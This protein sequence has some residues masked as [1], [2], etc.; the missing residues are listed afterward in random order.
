M[1]YFDDVADRLFRRDS[2]AQWH[3]FPWGFLGKGYILPD[4]SRK[5]QIHRLVKRWNIVST[6]LITL[7]LF[8]T[9]PFSAGTRV[10]MLSGLGLILFLLYHIATARQVRGYPLSDRRISLIESWIDAPRPQRL[11]FTRI[12][13]PFFVL[14]FLPAIVVLGAVAWILTRTVRANRTS[15]T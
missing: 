3:F 2:Q 13:G 15:K 4:E 10:L 6:L 7:T 8:G 5:R 12:L 11:I 14:I 1:R 9:I